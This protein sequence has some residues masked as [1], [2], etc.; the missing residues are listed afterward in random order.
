MVIA[1]YSSS[2]RNNLQR[3][4]PASCNL[5]DRYIRPTADRDIRRAAPEVATDLE[6]RILPC[7]YVTERGFQVRDNCGT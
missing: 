5:C 4:E 3:I 1:T 7:R 6:C 2:I